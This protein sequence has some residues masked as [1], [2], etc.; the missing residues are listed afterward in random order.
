MLILYF[1]RRFLIAFARVFIIVFALVYLIDFLENVSRSQR[2]G[3]SFTTVAKISALK[4]PSIMIQALSLIIMLSALSFSIGLARAQE[5]VIA[6]T[7]GL[8]ALRFLVGAGLSAFIVG[9]VSSLIFEPLAHSMVQYS[10]SYKPETTGN[11][12]S[13][14]DTGFW[15]RQKSHD[16]YIIAHAHSA[17][18]GGRVLRDVSVVE[19]N[20]VGVAKE[21]YFAHYGFL[22]E[23]QL[24]LQNVTQWDLQIFTPEIGAD[25]LPTKRFQVTISPEQILDGLP[26]PPSLSLLDLPSYIRQTSAAGLSSLPYEMQLHSLLSRP[27]LFLAMFLIGAVFTLKDPRIGNIRLAVLYAVGAGFA[28]YF[29]QNF[30]ITLGESEQVPV[31]IATWFPAL[32]GCF[33]TLALLLHYEDG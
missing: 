12:V 22:R 14:S 9:T 11:T 24:I 30:A 4:T 2:T 6:R 32:S 23:D 1:T 8:S 21:R 15:I 28:F 19:Y 10:E 5:F 27:F 33:L 13:V 17:E 26:A 18:Q 31:I 16:S 3:Y 25:S 29:M 20:N 7:G